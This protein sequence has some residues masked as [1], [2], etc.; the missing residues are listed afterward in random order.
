MNNFW[1][2][3]C[4]IGRE[5]VR[6]EKTT[7]GPRWAAHW[8]AARGSAWRRQEEQRLSTRGAGG[9]ASRL[10]RPLCGLLAG[11][12]SSSSAASVRLPVRGWG[13]SCVCCPGLLS[14][15]VRAVS[16]SSGDRSSNE[17]S[18]RVP[19]ASDRI[20]SASDNQKS[21]SRSSNRRES[22][23]AN[24]QYYIAEFS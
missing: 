11:S 18:A 21:S 5:R 20:R 15:I 19:R 12:P 16:R 10:E 6:V 24:K 23:K 14:S 17:G 13:C 9:G 7:S 4:Y 1:R 2:A 3:D 22:L 8:G